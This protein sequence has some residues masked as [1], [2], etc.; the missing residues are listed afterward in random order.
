MPCPDVLGNPYA[1]LRLP[2]SRRPRLRSSLAGGLPCPS[3]TEEEEGPPRC[4]AVLF[5]VP[6]MAA[7]PARVSSACPSRRRPP[8][9]S[10]CTMPWA[11][12]MSTVAV[13]PTANSLA[14]LRIGVFDRGRRKAATGVGGSPFT[15]RV[16]RPVGRRTKF[17][18]VTASSLPFDQP[19]LGR[20]VQPAAAR[21]WLLTDPMAR[22]HPW[23]R[24]R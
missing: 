14:C 21:R 8:S 16:S 15:G 5:S 12:R 22:S 10:G 19:C 4:R 24:D 18:D 13:N 20:T 11:P 1:A 9:P 17:H 7:D 23:P 2:P 6:G 3:A